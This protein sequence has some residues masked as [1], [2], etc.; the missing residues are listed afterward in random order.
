MADILIKID[1]MTCNHCKMA[2][3][4]ALAGIEGIKSFTVS[5][6][7]GSAEIVGNPNVDSVISAIGRAGYSASVDS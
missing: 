1:G 2:V 6:E 5:L 7:E 4:K 3:E